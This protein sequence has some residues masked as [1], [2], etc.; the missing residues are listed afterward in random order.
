MRCRRHALALI[1]CIAF[2]APALGAEAFDGTY[3]GERVLTKG[4]PAACTAKDPVS[5]VAHGNLLT[6]TNSKVKGYSIS[7]IPQADGSFG[8]QSANM[9][10]LKVAIHGHIGDGVLDSDVSS[11]YCT[12][13]WHAEKRSP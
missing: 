2:A 11:E 1:A 6:F 4:D 10:G 8:Q 12:H 13:H 7:L 5:V 9:G 3:T